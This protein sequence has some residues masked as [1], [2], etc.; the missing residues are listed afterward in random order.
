MYEYFKQFNLFIPI[1]DAR[2]DRHREK[3][4]IAFELHTKTHIACSVKHDDPNPV[5]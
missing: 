4:N 3:K 2:P 5:M 1:D